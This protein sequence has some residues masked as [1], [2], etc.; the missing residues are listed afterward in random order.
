MST[1][2]ETQSNKKKKIYSIAINLLEGKDKFSLKETET[3]LKEEF[4]SNN[5]VNEV[6]WNITQ[7]KF[8]K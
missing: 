2:T 5:L 3:I 6:L 4:K 1:I 8:I 7:K